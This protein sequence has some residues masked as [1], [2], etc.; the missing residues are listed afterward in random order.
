MH[1]FSMSFVCHFY[2]HGLTSWIWT[3]PSTK[4]LNFESP[5]KWNSYEGFNLEHWHHELYIFSA[6]ANRNF[7]VCEDLWVI[8]E[9]ETD[10][11]KYSLQK[12]EWGRMPK[13]WRLVQD[14]PTLLDDGGEI[15]KSQR[16]GWRFDSR[17]W[18]LLSTWHNFNLSGG[19]LPHMLWC[20]HVG[21]C[22]GIKIKKFG[23]DLWTLLFLVWFPTVKSPLYLTE[24]LL[25]GHLP[26][27]LDVGLS[28]FYLN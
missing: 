20:W 5:S 19:Q 23:G 4:G 13:Q 7:D 18:N 21:F 14:D 15:P 16:K 27:V 10:G 9:V 25:G 26:L 17:L 22:L 28:T 6:I 3:N 11:K 24:N 8:A 12:L 1:K 2:I